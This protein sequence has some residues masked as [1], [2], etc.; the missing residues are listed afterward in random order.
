MCE[1]LFSFNIFH[2]MVCVCHILLSISSIEGHLGCFHSLTAVNMEVPATIF[3]T[4]LSILL[5]IYPEVSGSSH[6]SIFN[7]LRNS[8]T[9]SHSGCTISIL[10]KERCCEWT[11][12]GGRQ[13]RGG[14]SG[15]GQQA[16]RG[17]G[18]EY[19]WSLPA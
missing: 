9:V 1:N 8:R 15:L 7:F 19:V 5:G 3:E 10:Q 16:P 18:L 12:E 4:L 2:S 17:L 11:P 13:S 14:E 6:S